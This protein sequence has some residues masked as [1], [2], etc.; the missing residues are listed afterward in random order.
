MSTYD[1]IVLPTPD[2]ID[3]KI[4]EFDNNEQ[5]NE[6]ALE[7]LFNT[8]KSNT[9]EKEILLKVVTLNNRYSAGLTDNFLNKEKCDIYEREN[10]RKPTNVIVMTKHIAE[11]ESQHHC[12]S[13]KEPDPI[14]IVK[15][16]RNIEGYQDSY[17]F[18]TKYVA[19]TFRDKNIPIVDG[20][21][22]KLLYSI[23][24]KSKEACF[25]E[26]LTWNDL[27]D[28]LTYCKVYELF[29]KHFKLE[30]YSYKQIDKY[31]WLYG[32]ELAQGKNTQSQG[33]TPLQ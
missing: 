30:K 3:K 1:D 25:Y 14:F 29:V 5:L 26:K 23:N 15:I 11:I 31:L 12:F 2:L 10:K 4:K 9:D 8:F 20:Y 27:E 16:L 22:K 17:S 28:Y 6:K 32:K 33:T 24:K 18:A 19:W 7:L 21:V 13:S